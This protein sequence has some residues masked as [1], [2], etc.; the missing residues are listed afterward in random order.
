ML[1]KS[2]I[3]RE[4]DKFYKEIQKG[5]FNI[6]EVTK[7]AL[8]QA[9]SK[10][11]PWAFIR[12]NEIAYTTFYSSTEV[13]TWHEHRVLAVDGTRMVLPNHPSIIAEFGQHEFGPHADSPRSLALGSMLYDVLNLVTLDAVIA[14]YSSSEREL[15]TQHHLT[16][17]LEGDLLLL[18]RGYPSILLMY[19]LK[20]KGIE[21]CMRMKEDWW[22]KVKELV[23]GTDK[24]QIIEFNLPQKDKKKLDANNDFVHSPLSVRLM[25]IKLEDGTT[26]VLCTSL[27]DIEKYKYEEFE[28][29]YHYRWNEEEAYKLLK[30]RLELENFTGKT[31]RAV[32]QDFH[33]K[34]FLMNLCAIFAHPIEEKVQQESQDKKTKNKYE[35]KINRTNALSATQDILIGIFIRKTINKALNAFDNIVSKTREII[36]PGRKK[37]RKKRPKRNYSM[38]Y[39]HL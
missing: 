13:Y 8:S 31:S 28:S 15:L 24:E 19:Q 5:D 27:T 36:R 17:M 7:G 9:R 14:P 3:Q 16:K 25:K 39:K 35:Q 33:A 21:F 20:A 30:S 6:R 12:L 32:Q 34:V 18:D 4:L 2:S 1:I 22:L 38:N 37:E 29:L 10:L 11:N 23:K 26:E